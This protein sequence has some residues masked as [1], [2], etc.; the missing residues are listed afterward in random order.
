MRTYDVIA[1]VLFIA[2]A[3]IALAARTW[4]ERIPVAVALVAAGLAVELIP[5]VFKL[6]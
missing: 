1:L 4:P 6:T 5:T 3:L 2:A